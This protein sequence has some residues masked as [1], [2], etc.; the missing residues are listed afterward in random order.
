MSSLI[1]IQTDRIV[2]SVI[3]FVSAVVWRVEKFLQL[4]NSEFISFEWTQLFWTCWYDWLNTA[5]SCNRMECRL[6]VSVVVC[7]WI[8]QS[9][10]HCFFTYKL[11]PHSFTLLERRWSF[12]VIA[13]CNLTRQLLTRLDWV[14]ILMSSWCFLVF[15]CFIFPIIFRVRL[16]LGSN[17]L[18][19]RENVEFIYSQFNH[20]PFSSVLLVD[21]CWLDSVP[22]QSNWKE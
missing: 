4:N 9:V 20:L 21:C 22:D 1:Y 18:Q 3:K 17:Q 11:H 5:I 15:W 7:K 13:D 12:K 10:V 6:I 19:I 16:G 14:F 8:H 2:Y